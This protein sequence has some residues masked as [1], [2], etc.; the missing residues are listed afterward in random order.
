MR[1]IL[2]LVVLITLSFFIF[3]GCYPSRK[4]ILRD[5]DTNS[6][7]SNATI[8]IEDKP[9]TKTVTDCN[10]YFETKPDMH[11]KYI[12]LWIFPV[13]IFFWPFEISQ[14]E[15][16]N[17]SVMVRTEEFIRNNGVATIH[18]RRQFPAEPNN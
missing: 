16:G 15:Y 5:A 11:P 3:T 4:G 6:P 2:F 10:G 17:Q 7:I 1:N 9:A 8:Q 14:R 18:I 13:D 12:F